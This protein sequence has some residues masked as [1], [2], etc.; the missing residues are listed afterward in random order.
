MSP[1]NNPNNDQEITQEEVI[2]LPLTQAV[3]N[4]ANTFWR[5]NESKSK[6]VSL[7]REFIEAIKSDPQLSGLQERIENL[8]DLVNSLEEQ[9]KLA[10]EQTRESAVN[11]WTPGTSKTFLNGLVTV[12]V[13]SS[14]VYYWD[15]HK[16][17]EYALSAPPELRSSLIKADKN[18]FK[19]FYDIL[20]VPADIMEVGEKVTAAIKEKDLI[21][22]VT[23]SATDP[24]SLEEDKQEGNDKNSSIETAVDN[25]DGLNQSK[26]ALNPQPE[27]VEDLWDDVPF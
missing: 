5:L 27:S 20:Q 19:K 14:H 22:F 11:E 1:Q 4:T 24:V 12:K 25:S 9:Y 7:Q 21:N 15:E 13:L 17:V 23:L 3:E 2:V 10:Q 8:S 18:G 16:A 26:N 6:L